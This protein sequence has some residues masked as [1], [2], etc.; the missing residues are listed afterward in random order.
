MRWTE[1]TS[2]PDIHNLLVALP[3]PTTSAPVIPGQAATARWRLPARVAFALLTA[4]VGVL[5][6]LPHPD[7]VPSSGWDKLDHSGGF[8]ALMAT[9]MPAR[10]GRAWRVA[11]VLV[12]YGGA[13]EL[14]QQAVPGRSAEWGDLLADAI[15]VG[16]GWAVGRAALGWLQGRRTGTP[17]SV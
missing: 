2:V 3:P 7:A 15:G 13:I 16:L 10:L 4:A 1:R 14:L 6:L 17:P 12:A 9:A 8:A 11:L 5:G